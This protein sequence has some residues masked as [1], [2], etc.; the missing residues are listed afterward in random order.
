MS[1]FRKFANA[2]AG[3]AAFTALMQVFCQFMAYSPGEVESTKEKLKLFFDP[4]NV[5]NYRVYLTL[6][7]LILLSLALTLLFRKQPYLGFAASLPPLVWVW[8]L[9][10]EGALYERPILFPLLLVIYTAGAVYD[11]IR[12]DREDPKRRTWITANLSALAPA[13]LCGWILYQVPK[14]SESL[15]ENPG[16]TEQ[17]LFNAITHEENFQIFIT[18]ALLYLG[19]VVLSL[20]CFE[21]YFVDGILSLIPLGYVIYHWY[22]GDF[23]VLGSVIAVLAILCAVIRLAAMFS[24]APKKKNG[25]PTASNNE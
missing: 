14:L 10:A 21:L 20:L 16:Y 25:F 11:C 3:F 22:T 24:C 18:V 6:T 2:C 9:F 23:P 19:S 17:L 13:A 8:L 1:T 12:L 5:K 15:P 4:E 7:A